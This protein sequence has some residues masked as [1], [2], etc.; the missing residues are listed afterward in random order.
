MGLWIALQTAFEAAWEAH[1]VA[2]VERFLEYAAWCVSDASGPLPNDT[3]TA[4][5]CGFY[6]DLPANQDRWPHFRRWFSPAM[7]EH[8]SAAFA[9]HL[10]PHD[11]ARL[12]AT[13]STGVRCPPASAPMARPRARRR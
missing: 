4:A 5:V 3:S 9:Y 10:E 2:A 6:E 13:F 7:F 8:L 11:M 1:D 12:R